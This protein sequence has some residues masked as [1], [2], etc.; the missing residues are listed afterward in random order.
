MKCRVN[1][2]GKKVNEL[3]VSIIITSQ[4]SYQYFIVDTTFIA[5]LLFIFRI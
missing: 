2:F 4:L 1:W 5:M 3:E